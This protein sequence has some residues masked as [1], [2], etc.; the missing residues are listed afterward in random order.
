VEALANQ[1]TSKAF[2]CRYSGEKSG[3][4]TKGVP[5]LPARRTFWQQHVLQMQFTPQRVREV[6]AVHAD[7]RLNT[8]P[9]DDHFDN[10]EKS[11]KLFIEALSEEL[12]QQA[13]LQR[14]SNEVS[15]AVS[16]MNEAY[17]PSSP[18]SA[19]TASSTPRVTPLT[20]LFRDVDE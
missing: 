5:G 19:P 18:T 7:E 20:T 14:V 12:D 10:F 1:G 16:A 17:E 2:Q 8:H 13:A 3:T 9:P 15:Y 4:R 6:Q 11:M